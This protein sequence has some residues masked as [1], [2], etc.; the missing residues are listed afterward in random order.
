MQCQTWPDPTA[1]YV[2]LNGAFP[3]AVA[4]VMTLL[5]SAAAAVDPLPWTNGRFDTCLPAH[6]RVL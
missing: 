2:R 5:H 3:V 4:F 6:A 1:S